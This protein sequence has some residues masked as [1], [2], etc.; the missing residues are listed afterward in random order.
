MDSISLGF[1]GLAAVL[2]LILL[3]INVGIALWLV[4]FLGILILKGANSGLA[5]LIYITFDATSSYNLAVIPLFMLMGEIIVIPDTIGS[6]FRTSRTWLGRLPGGLAVVTLMTNTG[7]AATTGSSIASTALMTKIALPE[8]LKAGYQKA[9]SLAVIAVSGSLAVLI[10]PSIFLV[11]YAMLANV[12]VGKQLLAGFIPGIWNALAYLI[13]ILVWAKLDPKSTPLGPKTTW[14]EKFISLKGI[15]GT[16]LMVVVILWGLYSGF[17]TSTEVGG[18]GVVLA[19]FLALISRKTTWKSLKTACWNSTWAT[20]MIFLIVAGAFVFST[21]LSLSGS[22]NYMAKVLGGLEVPTFVKFL[23]IILIYLILG[24]FVD[25]FSM[26]ALTLPVFLPV[27]TTL[28][29]DLIWF[30]V[31]C[32]IMVEVAGITPPVGLVVYTAAGIAGSDTKIMEV[33]KACVPFVLIQLVT[34]VSLYFLP[35]IVTFLPSIAK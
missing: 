16:A 18:L 24:C 34:V 30:G 20:G 6:F 14:K 9:Y 19:L 21:F 4:G 31:I 7:L 25:A 33:F 27:I 1:V 12:S 22:S 2:T 10:P 29:F 17:V 35:Q 32:V 23:V 11:F 8:M 15:W 13:V 3:G 28:G 5:S 26:L